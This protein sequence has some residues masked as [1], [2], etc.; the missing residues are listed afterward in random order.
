M[1]RTLAVVAVAA[2][3][4][5]SAACKPDD[6]RATPAAAAVKTTKIGLGVIPIVDVAPVYLGKAK[7]FFRSRGIDLTLVQEQSGGA[8]VKGVLGGKY[9][10]GFSNVTSLMAADADPS[11]ELATIKPNNSGATSMRGLTLNGRDF[12]TVASSLVAM[13]GSLA[14]AARTSAAICSRTASGM[15]RGPKM[16]PM[17]SITSAG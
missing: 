8:I 10:F 9:Q 15:P 13:V 7:G 4:L 6:D 12:K 14:T 16:P 5:T 3:L 2:M 17:L 11:F 1:R